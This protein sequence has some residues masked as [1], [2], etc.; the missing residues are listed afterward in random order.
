M[1]V[2]MTFSYDGSKFHGFQRLPNERSVQAEVEKVL[3]KIYGKSI[4]IKASGRTDAGVHANNQVAHY[5]A[6]N[7]IKHLKK[8]I[9]KLLPNDIRIKKIQYVDDN[10]HARNSAVKK[11][12]VYKINLGPYKS[13]MNDY[14]FQPNYKLD[15]SF[16]KEASKSFIG[17][18]D[19]SNFSSGDKENFVTT[20]HSITFVKNFGKLEIHFLGV[21][22]YRYMVRNIVGALLE[23]GKCKIRKEE[24]DSMINNPNIPKRLPTAK[25]EGLYLNKV[26][27]K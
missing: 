8:E 15:L 19:F 23:V 26:W 25:A 17:T 4:E 2:K 3:S 13:S 7:K 27:Y 10:F 20:I 24:I 18:H 5:D 14:L 9:N 16:M 12:Y 6:D 1:R 11:E 21:G 22:F